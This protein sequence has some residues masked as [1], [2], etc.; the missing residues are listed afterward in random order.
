MNQRCSDIARHQA[1]DR[2][3]VGSEAIDRGR[4]RARGERRERQQGSGHACA[5]DLSGA[6]VGQCCDD[7]RASVAR[8]ASHPIGCHAGLGCVRT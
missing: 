3:A 6:G 2:A 7:H 5:H 8:S 4:R 1:T